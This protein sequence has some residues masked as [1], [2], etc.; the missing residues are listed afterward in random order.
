MAR[1]R[2]DGWPVC[3]TEFHPFFLIWHQKSSSRNSI[4]AIPPPLHLTNSSSVIVEERYLCFT[5]RPCRKCWNLFPQDYCICR[6]ISC[7]L[8][9]FWVF[10]ILGCLLLTLFCRNDINSSHHLI[11]YPLILKQMIINANSDQIAKNILFQNLYSYCFNQQKIKLNLKEKQ[12]RNHIIYEIGFI[13]LF[14]SMEIP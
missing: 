11:T 4:D 8:F 7:C 3:F 12:E 14:K 1:C 13:T 10:Y 9:A 2:Q 5:P 6:T